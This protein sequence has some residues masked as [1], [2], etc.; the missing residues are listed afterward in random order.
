MPAMQP[1][2]EPALG[3]HKAVAKGEGGLSPTPIPCPRWGEKGILASG[4]TWG[5]FTLLLSD[6]LLSTHYNHTGLLK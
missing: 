1:S 6:W 2:D 4:S 3:R 5:S